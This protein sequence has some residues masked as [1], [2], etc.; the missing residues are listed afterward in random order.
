MKQTLARVVKSRATSTHTRLK[1]IIT[2]KL[3][4][5]IDITPIPSVPTVDTPVKAW[6]SGEKN[7]WPILLLLKRR[8]FCE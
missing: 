8:D 1:H 4:L 6:F 5:V 7:R 3:A 2:Y